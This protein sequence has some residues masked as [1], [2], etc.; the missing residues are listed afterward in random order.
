MPVYTAHG[1]EG[2]LEGFLIR[3]G[4][5]LLED[6]WESYMQGCML[7]RVGLAQLVKMSIAQGRCSRQCTGRIMDRFIS[8]VLCGLI[9]RAQ[10]SLMRVA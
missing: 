2:F 3:G 6:T 7:M 4:A 5:N 9:S 8:S 1:V 10:T